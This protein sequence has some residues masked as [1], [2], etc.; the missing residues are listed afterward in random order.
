MPSERTAYF[1]IQPDVNRAVFIQMGISGARESDG[2][3]VWNE[4]ASRERQEPW[5]LVVEDPKHGGKK[6]VVPAALE[7][8]G[9]SQSF[10]ERARVKE[11]LNPPRDP[12]KASQ[13]EISDPFRDSTEVLKRSRQT[14][15]CFQLC[16]RQG[17]RVYTRVRCK[18]T[19]PEAAGL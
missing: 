7:V 19:S 12:F 8:P 1:C 17:R 5:S 15:R 6:K 9:K 11:L 3:Q 4:I 10:S 2:A 13:G 18:H 14:I 16:F